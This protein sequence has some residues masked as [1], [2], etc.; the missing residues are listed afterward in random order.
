MLSVWYGMQFFQRRLHA[1]SLLCFSYY[2]YICTKILCPLKVLGIN[3]CPI[4]THPRLTNT[5]V[6]FFNFA[7]FQ[8]NMCCMHKVKKWTSHFYIDIFIYNLLLHH[9]WHI[10]ILS[11]RLNV[12][13]CCTATIQGMKLNRGDDCKVR[14]NEAFI[15]IWCCDLHLEIYSFFAVHI[16]SAIL[17]SSLI[18]ELQPS[19]A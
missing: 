19:P 6:F 13:R 18:L 8:M 9:S 1:L 10:S 14:K 7:Q 12:V 3:W 2:S 4:M 16:L 17:I 5:L 15:Y 11:L